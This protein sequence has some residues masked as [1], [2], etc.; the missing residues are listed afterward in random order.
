LAAACR[1][2]PSRSPRWAARNKD[3]DDDEEEE[4]EEDVD[5]DDDDDMA[6]LNASYL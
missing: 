4:D 6:E 3:E 5:D 1:L 2:T